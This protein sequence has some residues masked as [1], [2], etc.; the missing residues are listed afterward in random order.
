MSFFGRQIII[1]ELE[2]FEAGKKGGEK[3]L[4]SIK[5]EPRI[6]ENGRV[7]FSEQSGFFVMR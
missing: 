6:W 5:S 7:I 1:S 2:S 4:I 3:V